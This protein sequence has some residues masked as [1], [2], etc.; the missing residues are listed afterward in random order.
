MKTLARAGSNDKNSC[1]TNQKIGSSWNVNFEDLRF[2][3]AGRNKRWGILAERR[4]SGWLKARRIMVEPVF[5][6]G[7]YVGRS[8]L[9]IRIGEKCS[10][11]SIGRDIPFNSSSWEIKL[12]KRQLPNRKNIC[13]HLVSFLILIRFKQNVGSRIGRLENLC[14]LHGPP[15]R[16]R[17][18]HVETHVVDTWFPCGLGNEKQIAIESLSNVYANIL[19]ASSIILLPVI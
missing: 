18:F 10:F 6:A 7:F 8:H 11:L 4:I 15:G 9:A 16:V 3:R 14:W 17:I 5:P 2:L 12:Q 19:H 13:Y 1:C